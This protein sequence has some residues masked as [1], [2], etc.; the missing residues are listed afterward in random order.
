VPAPGSPATGNSAPVL[1]SAPAS[2]TGLTL[3]PA[4]GGAAPPPASRP[5][6]QPSPRPT[7]S[8]GRQQVEIAAKSTVG[9]NDSI[10]LSG[11]VMVFALAVSGVVVIAGRRA[12]RRVG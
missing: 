7:S 3:A 6:T 9:A 11:L 12:G 10:L 5:A 4:G 8:T 2:D 1:G